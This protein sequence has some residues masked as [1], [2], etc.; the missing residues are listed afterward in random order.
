L[1]DHDRVVEAA[2]ERLV[3]DDRDAV[4]RRDLTDAQGDQVGT[5]G[6][7]KQTPSPIVAKFT[8]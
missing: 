4:L 6:Q 5:L 3:L 2:G 1:I 7:D 8:A